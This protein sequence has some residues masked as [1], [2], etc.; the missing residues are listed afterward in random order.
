MSE[1]AR[2]HYV[3]AVV[4][5][6]R[7]T[8][9]Q[10]LADGRLA[11]KSFTA[12]H[13]CFLKRDDFTRIER[14]LRASRNV[15]TCREDGEYVR[16]RFVDSEARFAM[17]GRQGWFGTQGIETLEGDLHPVKRWLIDTRPVI[18]RPRSAYFDIETD[19]RVSFARKEEMRILLW[20]M[21]L[22][23]ELVADVLEE[24]SDRAER[25]LLE[26]FWAELEEADQAL[27]WN[28]DR[29]DF[30]VIAERSKRYRIKVDRRRWLWLD[31]MECF[32][33]Y[34]AHSTESGDEKDSVAL[35]RVS[36]SLGFDV[37]DK[38]AVD[39]SQSWQLWE[40]GGAS[41]DALL[42]RCCADVMLMRKIEE[43]TGYVDLHYTV[44]ATTGCFPET[45]SI[46]ALVQVEAFVMRLAA[47][48][49]LRFPTIWGQGKQERTKFKGAV[50]FAVKP[51]IKRDVHICDFSGMYPS[52]IETLNISPET[53]CPELSGRPGERFEDVRARLP[54]GYAVAP[55]TLQVFSQKVQGILPI[56]VVASR[57]LRNKYKKLKKAA[58]PQ[59]KEW[60]DADRGDQGGKIISNQNFGVACSP[61][62]RLNKREVGESITLTGKWLIEQTVGDGQD[63][64]RFGVE[65]GDT[66]SVFVTGLSEDRF[67]QFVRE[68]N[69]DLY[70]RLMQSLGC[71]RNSIELEY[72]KEFSLLIQVDKKKRYAGR[73][74][75]FKGSLAEIDSKPVIKGFEYKRG[76]STRMTR[77]FQE[78]VVRK[79]LLV[80]QPIPDVYPLN[81]ED[82]VEVIERWR[83]VTVD[84]NLSKRD[85]TISKS[86]RKDLKEYDR[87]LKKDGTPAAIAEHAAIA[88]V[89]L[90]RG[91]DVGEGARIEYIVV[92]GDTTPLGLIPA[93]D[94]QPGCEDRHYL[95]ERKVWP[96]TRRI[97]VA[98]WPT[99]PWHRYDETKDRGGG[100]GQSKYGVGQSHF[101]WF[102]E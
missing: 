59:S 7:L 85:V 47:E 18:Q 95:W 36:E 73:L 76:D 39:A 44:S 67:R 43:K 15:I 31:H 25:E 77:R 13:S 72:E 52:I 79:L 37:T 66:D 3:N 5:G 11:T 51:G 6:N 90:E 83:D 98:C 4:S 2:D 12:E 56:A 20:A 80:G 68:C 26:N 38:T 29:F 65:A 99:F 17:C 75:H 1:A 35:E 87:G 27:A 89:M 32:K 64:Y 42:K 58:V 102:G 63:R 16:V 88:K 94:Y 48:R 28:G 74:K 71:E 40:A 57:E 60:L 96:P 91:E 62:S 81:P 49:G 97:L 10:R 33:K 46:A 100:R 70:P 93:A 41:R 86:L 14:K 24:D 101:S 23:G 21:W 50:V 84:G 34:N 69:Q 78:E 45:R 53:H 92:E 9:Y 8:A 61:F 54:P 82:F 19:S 55:Y 30:E 22:N